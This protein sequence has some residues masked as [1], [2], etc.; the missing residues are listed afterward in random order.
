MIISG[1][2]KI[3]VLN[4]T[5]GSAFYRSSDREFQIKAQGSESGVA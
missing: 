2:D 3:S 1:T 5:K 4:K